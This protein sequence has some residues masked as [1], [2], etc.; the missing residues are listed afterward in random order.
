MEFDQ[1]ILFAEDYKLNQSDTIYNHYVAATRAKEK[2]IIVYDETDY[3]AKKFYC[4][5]QRIISK[6]NKKIEDFLTVIDE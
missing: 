6:R 3:N 5:L 2:L 4:N 1:V